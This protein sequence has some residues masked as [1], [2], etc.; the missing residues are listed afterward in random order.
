MEDVAAAAPFLY[1]KNYTW[2]HVHFLSVAAG[3]ACVGR[4]ESINQSEVNHTEAQTLSW[5]NFL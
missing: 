3:V 2:R 4:A 5:S 1:H